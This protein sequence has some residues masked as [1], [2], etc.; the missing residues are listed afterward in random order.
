MKEFTELGSGFKIAMRDLSIRGAGNL[1][2][3]QQH[4]FIDSVGF[5]LYSQ[6]LKEAIEERRGT[7]EEV[8]RKTVEIDLEIDAY[9]PDS[10]ISDGQQKIEMY[11]RFRGITDHEEIQELQDEMIDRFGEY[12]EE[13]M[14]LFKMTEIKVYALQLGIESIK[15]VKEEVTIL[16][17]E[18]A[19][20]KIDGQKV[21]QLTNQYGRMVG[22]GMEGQK[23]KM[24][25]HTKKVAIEKWLSAIYDILKGLTEE[26][27][28]S[29]R[30]RFI[31]WPLGMIF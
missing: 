2:G 8:K 26:K 31:V 9:I 6:M 23:F 30:I 11:K 4:G 16:L 17:S 20:G 28:E 7:I 18:E 5:D 24:V 12:P 1:L 29:R 13:L 27:E 14:Y 10:Y 22:L 25:I 21:F 15:Q 3:S 19:S